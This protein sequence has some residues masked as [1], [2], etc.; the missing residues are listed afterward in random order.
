MLVEAGLEM[1]EALL[2][3]SEKYVDDE[4]SERKKQQEKSYTEQVDCWC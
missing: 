1:A 3:I 2:Q 4:R